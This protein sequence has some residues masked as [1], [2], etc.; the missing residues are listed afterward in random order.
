MTVWL[1]VISAFLLPTVYAGR[2]SLH[3]GRVRIDHVTL[4]S[5][6]FIFY[7][8]TP[9]AAGLVLD[10]EV[11]PATWTG[12]FDSRLL[13]PYLAAVVAIYAAF[14]AGDQLGGWVFRNSTAPDQSVNDR[15]LRNEHPDQ[16]RRLPPQILALFSGGAFLVLLAE[17][18]V[19][20]AQLFAPYSTDMDGEIARGNV[21]AWVVLL[22]SIVFLRISSAPRFDR[23]MFTRLIL[24]FAAGALFLVAD[25]S[26]LY[27]ASFVLMFAVFRSLYVRPFSK[28]QVVLAGL[29]AAAVFGAVGALR[30]GSA[31]TDAGLNV[32]L[33][34]VFTSMSLVYFLR[35]QH[36]AWLALPKYLL[37]DFSNLIPSFVF[38]GKASFIQAPYFFSPVGALHSF[39]SFN[40]NFGVLGTATFMF[41]LPVGLRWIKARDGSPLFRTMYV[42]LSGWL[43]FT[44]FRDGFSVSIVKAMFEHSILLPAA[45]VALVRL[46]ELASQNVEPVQP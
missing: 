2:R 30:G 27:V 23:L 3:A 20:R 32:L 25:G 5:L 17:I 18:A 36:M 21:T 37:S 12:L 14:I 42:M 1:L 8:V 6:G 40:F 46:A 10:T 9:I 19:H 41:L 39:V 34:T 16:G 26:R 11:M 31:I 33:E 13:S 44:F 15:I 4:F 7:W 35:Y 22:G 24:P 29:F 38:P 28:K 43:A 45:I